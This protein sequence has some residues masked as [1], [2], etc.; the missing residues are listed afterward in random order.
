[1]PHLHT[2]KARESNCSR[3]LQTLV[4]VISI[5]LAF[6]VVIKVSTPIKAH[7]ILFASLIRP[8]VVDI[9]S[10]NSGEDCRHP[11]F[12]VFEYRFKGMALGCVCNNRIIHSGYCTLAEVSAG[13]I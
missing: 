13:C 2:T 5:V 11:N 6:T 1:M 8:S 10:L 9:V 7:E 3:I 4:A 12:L